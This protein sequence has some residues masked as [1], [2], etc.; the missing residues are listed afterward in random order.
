MRA[1]V[2]LLAGLLIL[3]AVSGQAA[4][5]VAKK[6][7][8]PELSTAPPIEHVAEGC[9]PGWHRHHWRDYWGRWHWGRCVPNW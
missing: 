4:P 2:P 5:F 7:L 9:G 6:A 1:I 3:T 8:P